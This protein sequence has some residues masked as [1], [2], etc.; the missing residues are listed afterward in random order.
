MLNSTL[1][2]CLGRAFSTRFEPNRDE[3]AEVATRSH[4]LNHVNPEEGY[5]ACSGDHKS[6]FPGSAEVQPGGTSLKR[7]I[8]ITHKLA[9]TKPYQAKS[10]ALVR[11]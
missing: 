8:A 9:E 2:S 7:A 1:S 3:A 10:S 5:A 4:R 11:N 6:K